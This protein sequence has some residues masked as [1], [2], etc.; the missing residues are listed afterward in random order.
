MRG[1]QP[2]ASSESDS[3]Y[4]TL[5]VSRDAS[6]A[7]IRKACAPR[8]CADLLTLASHL[9][10]LTFQGKRVGI[11]SLEGFIFFAS[12]GQIIDQTRTMLEE[13]KSRDSAE[14]V[15]PLAYSYLT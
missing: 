5:G 1:Y 10:Q 3:H 12:A 6:T 8:L 4:N 14:Q 2:V 7:D 9:P 15:S 11:I 13:S